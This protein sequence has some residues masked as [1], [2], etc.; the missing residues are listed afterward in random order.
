MIIVIYLDGGGAKRWAGPFKDDGECLR[1]ET[2]KFRHGGM[3]TSERVTVESE[4]VKR[5]GDATGA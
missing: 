3:I 4:W 2:K 5:F 1:F